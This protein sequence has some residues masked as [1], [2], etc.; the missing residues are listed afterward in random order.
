[1]SHTWAGG[2]F[3]WYLVPHADVT[4]GESMMSAGADRMYAFGLHNGRWRTRLV[5]KNTT[6]GDDTTTITNKTMFGDDDGTLE[7]AYCNDLSVFG[8]VG[9]EDTIK[10][11]AY[12]RLVVIAPSVKLG[13]VLDNVTGDLPIVH[14]VR[15]GSIL[16]GKLV[17]GDFLLSVNEID[18][19]GMLAQ[20]VS[21][22]ITHRG[23]CPKR[24]LVL[25]HRSLT[26]D[27]D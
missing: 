25:L 5:G 21:N 13:L 3:T 12:R 6:S 9:G 8:G 10:D 19:H 18:C 24:W 20:E 14:A 23:Q 4:V 15:D 16:A 17:V 2:Y 7:A 26:L 22:V 1:M 11:G 27:M